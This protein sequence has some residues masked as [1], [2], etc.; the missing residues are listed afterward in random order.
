MT[1]QEK[2]EEN[3]KTMQKSLDS[4]REQIKLHKGM[5]RRNHNSFAY[6]GDIT[7]V[8]SLLNEAIEFLS[9]VEE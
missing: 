8:T 2:Y 7:Y 1:A 5:T 3:I 4:L 6:C 9:G